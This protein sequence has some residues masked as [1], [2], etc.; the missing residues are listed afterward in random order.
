MAYMAV[1]DGL[2]TELD[3]PCG[4]ISA[5]FRFEDSGQ[6]ARYESAPW[7]VSFVAASRQRH[8]G[9]PVRHHPARGRDFTS[10]SVVPDIV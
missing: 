4:R 1:V 2:E 8:T 9:W 6:G 5:R 10:L 7:S 3:P